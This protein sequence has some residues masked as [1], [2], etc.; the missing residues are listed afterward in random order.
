MI[1]KDLVEKFNF[2]LLTER[3]GLEKSVDGVYCCDLLSWVMSH[4]KNNDAWITV[5]THVNV[6]AVASLL[7]LSCVIIPE[8]IEVDED[9]IA[10]AKKEGIPILSTDLNAYGIF[11]KFY[12]AGMR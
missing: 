1:V 9:T 2:K 3:D 7:N 5:Q 11:S 6:V 4:A 8:S 12:E 10:K